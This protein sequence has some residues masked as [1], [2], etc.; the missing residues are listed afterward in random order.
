MNKDRLCLLVPKELERVFLRTGDLRLS[1]GH[2][3]VR[4]S[5]SLIHI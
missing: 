5:L 1:R 4:H 3:N 2:V